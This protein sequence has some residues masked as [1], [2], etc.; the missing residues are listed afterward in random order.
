MRIPIRRGEIESQHKRVNDHHLTPATIARLR[1]DLAD[2]EKNVMPPAAAE[3]RRTAEMGDLSENAAYQYAK[4]ALR[5][6]NNRIL[7]LRARITYAYP[8]QT[9]PTPLVALY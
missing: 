7:S 2:L 3:L 9:D 8:Y 1:R 4:D 5:R 6:I